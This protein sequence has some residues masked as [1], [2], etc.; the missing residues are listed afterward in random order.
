MISKH[1]SSFCQKSDDQPLNKGPSWHVNIGALFCWD[2]HNKEITINKKNKIS[3]WSP[4]CPHSPWRPSLL[5]STELWKQCY[6][7]EKKNNVWAF[8]TEYSNVEFLFLQS[9]LFQEL[10]QI[11]V[12]PAM[13]Y[14]LSAEMDTGP[15]WCLTTV[16]VQLS[17][18]K[19]EGCDNKYNKTKHK[20]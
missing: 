10:V 5:K 7:V 18:L 13:C 6:S 12:T 16:R 20:R 8:G 9:V 14:V 1:I 17:I 3:H 4:T 2:I 11:N 15:Q 19:L